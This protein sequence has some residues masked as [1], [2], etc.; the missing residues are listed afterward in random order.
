MTVAFRTRRSS[1]RGLAARF[2]NL[3]TYGF[4]GELASY[5]APEET[6]PARRSSAPGT[7]V[8]AERTASKLAFAVSAGSYLSPSRATLDPWI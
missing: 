6:R 4:C 3:L 7:R 8:T 5:P 1:L 2:R